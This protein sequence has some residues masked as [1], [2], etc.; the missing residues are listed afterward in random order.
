LDRITAWH[1]EFL[2]RWH[3]KPTTQQGL[4]PKLSE[5]GRIQR[6]ENMFQKILNTVCF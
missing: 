1:L 2:L 3:G 5:S 6:N 4:G